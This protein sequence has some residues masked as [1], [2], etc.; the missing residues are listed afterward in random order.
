MGSGFVID[1]KR[2]RVAGLDVTSWQDDPRLRLVMG[3]DG[4]RRKPSAWIRAVVLHTTKGLRGGAPLPGF[5]RPVSAGL[6]CARYWSTDGRR[7]GAHIVVDHD[8]A[9]TCLA[10]LALEVANHCPEW[11]AHSVGIEL[12][13]GAK[14]ELYEGQLDVCVAVCD[15]LTRTFGIQRQIPHQYLGALARFLPGDSSVVGVIGHRDAAKNRDW[16]DPG[17]AIFNRLGLAGYESLNF[18]AREDLDVWRRRQR[19]LGIP[20]GDG[21]P[22]PRTITVLRELGRPHGMW[23]PRP[24]DLPESVRLVT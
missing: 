16:G 5:G 18:D 6:R 4:S 17:N 24:G 21:I 11:N 13:Q 23:V 7:A 12:Y 22:G 20:K 15:F 10:D 2:I 14:G 1:G 19:D 8:G 9:V 3:E